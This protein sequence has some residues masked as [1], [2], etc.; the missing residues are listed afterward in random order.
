[1]VHYASVEAL[2]CMPAYYK[3]TLR[4]YPKD[5]CGSDKIQV[6]LK[7][8][9]DDIANE[10]VEG[11]LMGFL[12]RILSPVTVFDMPADLVMKI[13]GELKESQSIREQL[14]KK[15]VILEGAQRPANASFG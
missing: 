8:F 15:L 13:A 9:L 7:R 1:M 3:V 14:N 4:P 5:L 11:R 6:A 2:D 10:I 12:S